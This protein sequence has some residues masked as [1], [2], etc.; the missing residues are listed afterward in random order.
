MRRRTHALAIFAVVSAAG[1][2]MAEAAEVAPAETAPAEEAASL[3][4]VSPEASLP[5]APAAIASEAS[6]RLATF[7]VSAGY[8]VLGDSRGLD[9]A[10]GPTVELSISFRRGEFSAWSS[11]IAA[12]AALFTGT[13][14]TGESRSVFLS[15][16]LSFIR[17]F[18]VWPLRRYYAFAGVEAIQEIVLAADGDPWAG[19]FAGAVNVGVGARLAG[20][21]LDL[22]LTHGF[23][24]LSDNLDAKTTL[25]VGYAF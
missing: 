14:E 22:R 15:E 10:N 7:G 13:A 24:F 17:E 8:V 11:E 9:Y 18:G 20:R 25:G 21:R 3:D 12:C 2:S 5:E 23:L 4:A 6:P 19:N 1:P 16:R